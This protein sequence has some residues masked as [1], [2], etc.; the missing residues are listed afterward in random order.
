M[1]SFQIGA[2]AILTIVFLG[3]LSLG[4]RRRIA[5]RVAFAWGCLWIAAGIA[6]ARPEITVTVAH[7]LGIMRGADLV[8]YLAILGMFFGFFAVSIRLRKIDSE[9]TRVVRELALRTPQ[10]DDQEPPRT[11]G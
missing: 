9:I 10:N 8:F 11:A 1:T 4:L 5:P 6:I 3:T 7:A 2:V